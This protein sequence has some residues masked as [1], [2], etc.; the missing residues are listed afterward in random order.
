MYKYLPEMK[1]R[2]C[3]YTYAESWDVVHTFSR[4]KGTWP[5]HC[6]DTMSIHTYRPTRYEFCNDWRCKYAQGG[7][8]GCTCEGTFHGVGVGNPKPV[9]YIYA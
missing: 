4:D 6:G 7:A 3:K 5:I 9:K 1:C 8:C 2:H